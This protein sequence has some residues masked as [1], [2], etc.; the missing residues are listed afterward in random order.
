[1][2]QVLRKP[3]ARA[4]STVSPGLAAPITKPG[5]EG[6]HTDGLTS[7]MHMRQP[8]ECQTDDQSRV[9]ISTTRHGGEIRTKRRHGKRLP[10]QGKGTTFPGS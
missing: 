2:G 8:S 3:S 7:R 9:A 6:S 5:N 4:E 10:S 1:M